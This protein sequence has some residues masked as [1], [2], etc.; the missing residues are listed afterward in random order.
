MPIQKNRFYRIKNQNP[1]VLELA[2]GKGE[3]TIG[4]AEKFPDK[5][6]VGVDLKGDRIFIG[7]QQANKKQLMNVAFVRSRIELLPEIFAPRPIVYSPL[8]KS[9]CL[10]TGLW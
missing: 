5:N 6:H 3:Y 10:G 1:V 7:S 4:L 9:C 8:P 2:C